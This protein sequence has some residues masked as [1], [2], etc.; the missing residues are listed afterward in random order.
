MARL[1]KIHDKVKNALIKDGWTITH[2]PFAIQFEELDLY[3]DLAAERVFAAERADEK[4]AVE[5]KSF[6][7]PSKVQDF[8]LA[9]GQYELYKEYMKVLTP[10]R[11]LFLAIGKHIFKTFFQK[12]AVQFIINHKQ[13]PLI[14]VN[15]EMEEIVEWIN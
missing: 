4:I 11:K 14:I 12:K 6:L 7:L 8:K 1:D 9:L 13:L 2:D 15:L 3:V 10:D 5:I